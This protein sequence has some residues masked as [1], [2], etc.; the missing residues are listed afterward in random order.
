MKVKFFY[1]DGLNLS[2]EELGYGDREWAVGD[3]ISVEDWD[4]ERGS[5]QDYY[6][7]SRFEADL[8]SGAMGAI[9]RYSHCSKD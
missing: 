2:A 7:I 6:E 4:S 9:V 8:D 3:V 1:G 5:V